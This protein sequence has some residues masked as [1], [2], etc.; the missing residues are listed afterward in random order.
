[1][2][3]GKSIVCNGRTVQL[4]GVGTPS[5][6]LTRS[7]LNLGAGL[8]PCSTLLD[9]DRVDWHTR[10]QLWACGGI[11]SRHFGLRNSDS[12]SKPNCGRS[13][14]C[15]VLCVSCSEHY[16]PQIQYYG[17]GNESSPQAC[18]SPIAGCWG[19]ACFPHASAFERTGFFR[20]GVGLGRVVSIDQSYKCPPQGI[21]PHPSWARKQSMAQAHTPTQS[22]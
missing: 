10:C 14:S 9:L 2:S 22:Q 15:L 21:G 6:E 1:M 4:F 17:P 12:E 18:L 16:L 3:D 19:W 5:L 20:S 13:N 8:R 11:L 7:V